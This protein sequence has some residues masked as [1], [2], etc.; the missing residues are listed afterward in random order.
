MMLPYEIVYKNNIVDNIVRPEMKKMRLFLISFSMT[1]N[2]D[3][4]DETIEIDRKLIIIDNSINSSS[5]LLSMCFIT[6]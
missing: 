5:K 2:V 6:I 1:T 4:N 3:K